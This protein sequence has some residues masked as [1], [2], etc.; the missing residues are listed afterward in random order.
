MITTIL[1]LSTLQTIIIVYVLL[2]EFFPE[3]WYPKSTFEYTRLRTIFSIPVVLLSFVCMFYMYSLVGLPMVFPYIALAGLM[4][5]DMGRELFL[6]KRR[7]VINS[8]SITLS[9]G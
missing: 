6:A 8:E 1:W 2:R 5:V 9:A 4:I 3:K 7:Q